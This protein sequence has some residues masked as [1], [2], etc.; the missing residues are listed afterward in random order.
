[1]VSINKFIA[2]L[3]LL[4]L[5]I[6]V[7]VPL[8]WIVGLSFTPQPKILIW[9]LKIL[10]SEITFQNYVDLLI[11]GSKETA[12]G[13]ILR[14]MFN[15]LL[16]TIVATCGVLFT[17]S[18]AAYAF[19]RIKFPAKNILFV[20]FGISILVPQTMTLIPNFMIMRF[21]GWIDTYHALIWPPLGWFFAVF[22]LRQFMMSIPEELSDAA[23]IDGCSQ[24]GVYRR[25]ILPLAKAPMATLGIFTF[26]VIWNDFTW[27]YLVLN[28]NE[29]RTLPIGLSVLI[30]EHWT[31]HGIVM[32]GAVVSSTPILIFYFIFQKQITQAVMSSGFG[33]R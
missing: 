17:S 11:R 6:M 16:V 9:P 29:M 5:L 23:K 1:M 26:L 13:S 14:W 25:I 22:F 10:P 21:L 8:V 18:M 32:A 24:F 20:I 3:W 27:P 15:S 12:G 7:C 4:I 2:Y 31:E 30:G 19:A 28:S 33:G